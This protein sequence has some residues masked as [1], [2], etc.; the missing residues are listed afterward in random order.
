MADNQNGVRNWESQGRRL[1]LMPE[2]T[3]AL[4][5]PHFHLNITQPVVWEEARREFTRED[6]SKGVVTLT[7][8]CEPCERLGVKNIRYW[9]Y[10]RHGEQWHLADFY[11]EV[12]HGG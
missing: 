12:H 6:G 1:P 3:R 11:R 7:V 5:C 10:V 4:F 9:E 2:G 8:N